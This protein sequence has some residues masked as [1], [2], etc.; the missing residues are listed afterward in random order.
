MIVAAALFARARGRLRLPPHERRRQRERDL[1]LFVAGR[2]RL[3]LFLRVVRNFDYRLAFLLLPCRSSF[4]GHTHAAG[5]PLVSLV[6][7]FGTLWLDVDLTAHVPLLGA[8]VRGFKHATTLGV[9]SGSLPP[10]V[11][12]QFV[13]FAGLVSCLVAIVPLRLPRRL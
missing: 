9:F 4:V 13:L 11:I 8:A 6:G 10:A 12:M 1:D 5:S 7:L 2:G 3:P